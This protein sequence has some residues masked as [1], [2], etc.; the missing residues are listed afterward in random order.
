MKALVLYRSYFGNTK[1]LAE[2]MAR[3]ISDLGH[4]TVVQDLRRRLP[5]LEHFDCVMIGAPTR[6]A[7]VNRRALRVLGKLRKAGFTG[8]P[9]AIFDTFGPL[10]G[11]PEELEKARK[12]ITPGAAGIMERSARGL[13]LNV[14]GQA[15]R[16]EVSGLKGPLAEGALEKAAA[17]ARG[18]A[19]S[20]H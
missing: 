18:L 10:P 14:H 4:E 6:M 16:I 9:V 15:L 12:W 11:T 20:V 3:G 17:F 19:Q 1:A 8:K 7:R 13:G 5:A 2:A